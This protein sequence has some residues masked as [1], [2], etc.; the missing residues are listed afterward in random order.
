V[1]RAAVNGRAFGTIP[2]FPEFSSDSGPRA[3]AYRRALAGTDRNDTSLREFPLNAGLLASLSAASATAWSS[4]EQGLAA[5]NDPHERPVVTEAN[6]EAVRAGHSG[7][8]L[9][10]VLIASCALV[11]VGF[12]MVALFVK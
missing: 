5:M 4:R 3:R 11:V 1:C 10:Y 6:K 12:I 2:P 7:D 8:G 9:R